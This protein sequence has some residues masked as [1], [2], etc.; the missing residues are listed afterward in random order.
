MY[1]RRL[2]DRFVLGASVWRIEEIRQDRVIVSPTVGAK[3]MSLFGKRT[4]RAVL[5]DQGKGVQTFPPRHALCQRAVSMASPGYGRK[6]PGYDRIEP[7][8]T[9]ILYELKYKVPLMN[10][11]TSSTRR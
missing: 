9:P 2:N 4:R 1:E 11:I 3:L 7:A 10:F 6:N 5:V 8:S